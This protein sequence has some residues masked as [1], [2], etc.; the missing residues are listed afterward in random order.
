MSTETN[1]R[2]R[3]TLE[4]WRKAKG[5]SQKDFAFKLGVPVVTYA[6][7]DKNPEKIQISKA[8]KIARALEISINDIIFITANDT[9]CVTGEG[10]CD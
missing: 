5:F 6:R 4:G 9:K 3:F 8:E 10:K 1:E 7:W 2:V